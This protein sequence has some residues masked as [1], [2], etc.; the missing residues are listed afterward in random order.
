[1]PRIR[2]PASEKRAASRISGGQSVT[3]ILPATKAKLQ[4][5]Q[6]RPLSLGT[7]L[8]ATRGTVTGGASDM[9]GSPGPH[10]VGPRRDIRKLNDKLVGRGNMNEPPEA[11]SRIAAQL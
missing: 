10:R 1:M 3:P 2:M 9:E 6:H 5:R 8:Q 7:G 4:S 11:R